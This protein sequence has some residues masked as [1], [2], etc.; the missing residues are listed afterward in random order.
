MSQQGEQAVPPADPNIMWADI[1]NTMANMAAL[2]QASLLLQQQ[3]T[4]Q[5]AE[6]A[7]AQPSSLPTKLIAN[8]GT[9]DGNWV[10]FY[11][12]WVKIMTWVQCQGDLD[13]CQQTAAVLLWMNG[14][15]K[16]F[17]R[18][19]LKKYQKKNS[20]LKWPTWEELKKEVE[21]HF[22]IDVLKEESYIHLT[23]LQQG[24]MLI[25]VFTQQFELL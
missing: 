8:P 10:T 7:M 1:R 12:W 16:S 6:V 25:E 24:S 9:W 15:A 14:K 23:N 21:G 4:Q 11:L 13:D 18:I 5:F 3:M 2:L 17:A 22:W 19:I 20:T